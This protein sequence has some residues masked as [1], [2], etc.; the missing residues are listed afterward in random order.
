MEA[1]VLW[2]SGGVDISLVFGVFRFASW[3]CLVGFLLGR[4]VR[5]SDWRIL[6][7]I[8]DCHHHEYSYGQAPLSGGLLGRGLCQ[9]GVGPPGAGEEGERSCWRALRSGYWP[10]ETGG[11]GVEV[12]LGRVGAGK[13]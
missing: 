10:G 3:G 1:S 9:E 13:G 6:S 5:P 2:W 8:F 11:C 4:S 7:L 12:G